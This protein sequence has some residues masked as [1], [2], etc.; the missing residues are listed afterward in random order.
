MSKPRSE[1]QKIASAR[2]WEILR[3]KSIMSHTNIS[4][5]TK[6]ESKQIRDICENVLIRNRISYINNVNDLKKYKEENKQTNL[7]DVKC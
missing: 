5:F 6:E 2:A 1:L 7:L 4:L 3:L